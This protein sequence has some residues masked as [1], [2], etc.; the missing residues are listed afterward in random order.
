M[1]DPAARIGTVTLKVNNLP[2][3]CAFYRDVVGLQIRQTSDEAADLGTPGETL[4][5]LQQLANGRFPTRSAGLY[6]LALRLATRSALGHWLRHYAEKGAPYWQGASDHGVSEALYLTDPEGNGLELYHDQPRT[7]WQ[8]QPDGQIAVFAHR[9]DVDALIRE[10]PHTK[11]RHLPPETD[12]G[13]VHFKVSDL[14]QARHFYADLCGF[15]IKTAYQRSALFVAAGDYH[16]HIGLNTWRSLAAPP[17]PA[18]AYG[19]AETEIW[20]HGRSEPGKLAARLQAADYPVR[21]DG[22]DL[23]VTDPAGIELRFSHKNMN[24]KTGERV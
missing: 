18:E 1:I 10:A 17:L 24:E 4:V 3:M 2:Q 8:I 16:H 22:N 23:L 19:L 7:Q 20:L 5:R 12:M 6:H 15:Q 21:F 9:L 14:D 13:H 11:W